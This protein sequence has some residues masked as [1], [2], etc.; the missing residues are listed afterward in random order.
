MTSSSFNLDGTVYQLAETPTGDTWIDGKPIFRRIVSF[1]AGPNNAS[2]LIAHGITSMDTMIDLHATMK[3]PTA[4]IGSFRQLSFVGD[5][6]ADPTDTAI[7]LRLI[8]ANV[9]I[10]AKANYSA[11]AGQVFIEYTK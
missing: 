6:I 5:P 4:G 9:E 3:A 11:S 8:D 7:L 10:R 1:A 2:I